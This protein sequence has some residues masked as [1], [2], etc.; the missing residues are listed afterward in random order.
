MALDV[1]YKTVDLS[2]TPKLKYPT[3]WKYAQNLI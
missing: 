2:Q 1:T 3:G